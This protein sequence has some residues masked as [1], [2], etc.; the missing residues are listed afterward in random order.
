MTTPTR[1]R[2][3]KGY[4]EACLRVTSENY[5]RELRFS[6]GLLLPLALST[7]RLIGAMTTFLV[8]TMTKCALLFGGFLKQK[9][10]RAIGTSFRYG[11]LPVNSSA[12]GIHGTTIKNFAALRLLD[13]QFT[14]TT[15][16]G[17]LNARRFLFDVFAL[18]IV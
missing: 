4:R 13:Y 3:L 17:T 16:S 18:R 12:I 2:T 8:R 7:R 9:R 14:F 11:L 15:G 10:R 1:R 6:S 5:L